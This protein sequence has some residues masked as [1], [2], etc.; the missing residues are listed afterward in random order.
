MKRALR[1]RLNGKLFEIFEREEMVALDWIRREQGLT[2]TKEGCREGDCGACMVLLGE[3]I[4][5]KS[6]DAEVRWRSAL[7]C[8][9]ALG[10]LDGRHVVTIEGIG[11]RGVTPVM[12]A[13]LDE[14]ASQCG[15]CSPGFVVSL[16]AYLLRGGALTEEGAIRA[17]EGNLCRCTGY[18]SIKRAGARLVERFG[19]L[20]EALPQRLEELSR[21]GVIPAEIAVL[22]SDIPEPAGSVAS[23]VPAGG[24]DALTIGGGTDFF[25]RNPDPE[26]QGTV[27]FVDR[28]PA[29][30]LI[31]R[32]EQT[33]RVG[34]SVSVQEFFESSIVRNLFP[35]IERYE[36]QFASLPIRTRA[37]LAG[38]IT[39]ASPIGDMTAILL[40]LQTNV[41]IRTSTATRTLPLDSYFVS[42]RRTALE[43][44]EQVESLLIPIPPKTG[45]AVFNF[46]KVAKRRNLDIASA[47][48]ACLAIADTDRRVLEISLSAGGVGPVPMRLSKTEAYLRGKRVDRDIASRAAKLAGEECAPI[49][50]VRGSATYRR[51]L[52]GRFIW[53]HLEQIFPELD[54]IKEL[55]A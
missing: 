52:L 13:M 50:D 7:S 51:T 28:D 5:T 41:K 21:A 42:Y 23:N 38:N 3:R 11:A 10:E 30:R 55:L 34:A 40:A 46:E 35:G 20:P 17:V 54:L 33:I 44:A 37:T 8:L 32:D 22:M 18:G 43:K 49:D 27:A 25:V 16:T 6:A 53:A 48:S 2:G 9:L 19:N 45:R 4:Q 47:N 26:P 14:G 31:S 36:S 39:N 29:L 12:A 15:F 1:F 24:E